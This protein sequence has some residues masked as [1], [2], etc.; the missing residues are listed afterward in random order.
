MNQA[1]LVIGIFGGI[2]PAARALDE[3]PGS[4]QKWKKRGYVP[5]TKHQKVLDCA[6]EL[7]LKLTAQML[8]TPP[9]G[10]G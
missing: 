5:A 7:K 8:L 3:W 10:S 1:D 9:K 6:K 4:V 2:R